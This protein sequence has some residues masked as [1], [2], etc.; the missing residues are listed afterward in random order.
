MKFIIH[1]AGN[2]LAVTL[3]E[4]KTH[5][6][7]THTACHLLCLTR[8]GVCVYMCVRVRV[9]MCVRVRVLMCVSMRVLMCVRVRVL[10][11]MSV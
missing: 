6:E 8:A 2:Q 5:R 1:M 10:M 11:C 9:P 3:A 7:M 4:S